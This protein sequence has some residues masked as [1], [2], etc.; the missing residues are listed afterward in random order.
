MRCLGH[1]TLLCQLVKYVSES[2]HALVQLVEIYL[3]NDPADLVAEIN[4]QP[5]PRVYRFAKGD[6]VQVVTDRDADA[7]S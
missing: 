3:R 7:Q 6:Q 5:V 2:R 1:P 4:L